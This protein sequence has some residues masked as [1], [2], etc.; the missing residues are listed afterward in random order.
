MLLNLSIEVI[1]WPSHLF[2]QQ[3]CTEWRRSVGPELVAK[4]HQHGERSCYQEFLPESSPPAMDSGMTGS[5]FG[6]F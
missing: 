5:I 2:I 1:T 6:S 3:T 4:P